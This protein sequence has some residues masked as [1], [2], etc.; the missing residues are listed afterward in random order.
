MKLD[1]VWNSPA[2]APT[3]GEGAAAVRLARDTIR[4]LQ[5]R[6]AAFLAWTG[7]VLAATTGL[8]V[9]AWL[10]DAA[11]GT[12]A[13]SLLLAA[14]WAVVFYLLRQYL[15]T[16]RAALEAGGTV[17]A[18]L[19]ALA[20]EAESER[21]RQLVVLALF[22]G[23]APLLAGALVELRR[24]GRMAPDEAVSA[25]LVLAALVATSAAAVAVRLARVTQPRC[26][27][28]RALVEQYREDVL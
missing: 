12:L 5:R 1:D 6:R 19:E 9:Y 3:P 23:A 22:A 24:S 8:G 27:R 16:R 2:N 21:R 15:H 13:A 17:R 20:R 14:Q 7:A 26:R 25:A 10:S 28:L 18:S 4:V 11:D